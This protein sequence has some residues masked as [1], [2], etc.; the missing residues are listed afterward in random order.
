MTCDKKWCGKLEQQLILRLL[1]AAVVYQ[2]ES[3][4]PLNRQQVERLVKNGF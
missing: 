2:E 4:Q 3:K 1:I